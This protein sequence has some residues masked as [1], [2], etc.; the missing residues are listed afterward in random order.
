MIYT[1]TLN[2]SIDYLVEVESFQMGKVNRTSYD[3]KFPGG[4]GINVSRV[5]KRLGNSTTAL[6]FIGGQT[7]EFVKRFLRQEEIFTDFTEIAGDT[8]INIKLKTGMETEINSQGPVISKGNY[9]QLFSQIEQLNNNDILILSGSIPS[10]VPSDVYETM[11]RSCSH[12]GIKVVVDTSGKGLMNVLPHQPFL[13]KPNHHELGELF[14]TEIRTVDDAREYGA[15]LVEAGAQNVIVSMAG[16]GAVLC[17][18]GESYS[19]NVPKGNV[20][21]SVGAGDSMVAG[22][23]G[24]YEKTGDILTAFRFSL[25]A[26]SATAFSSDL[27]TLDKIEELL[28]QIAINQLTGG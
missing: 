14:S 16:Q 26:G 1:V 18:G 21:N 4:K 19:A 6:G 25:A 9:Q 15:K 5:L 23:I 3:A 7:G 24:T 8:R 2:P 22:F 12:N 20:I 11:A 13:I 10:S 28:P 17:S 27:G